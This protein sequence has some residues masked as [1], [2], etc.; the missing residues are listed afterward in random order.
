MD[1]IFK[2]IKI[3]LNISVLIILC[4]FIFIIFMP[5]HNSYSNS[6]V[7][8]SY[9]NSTNENNML[10]N[11][12]FSL[13]VKD[14]TYKT[15]SV[16]NISK[17]KGFYSAFREG[18]LNRAK[19]MTEV[20]WTPKYNLIEKEGFYVFLKGKTYTGVPYSMDP[21]QVS[22]P[23][24]FLYMINDSKI[25][26][27]NDCSGFVSA[28]WGVNRQ[29]TLTLLN[30]VKDGYKLDGKT[31]CQISWDD[32]EPG[33]ALLLDNGE[34]DGHVMLYIDSDKNNSDNLN[35]YEQNIAT[36]TPYEPIPVAREDVRSKSLLMKYGYI[37]IRII[38]N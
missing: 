20:K 34:G 21:Y 14:V 31:V 16:S 11:L 9:S 33:D 3:T 2:S 19:A 13:S 8:N 17:D 5:V 30:E 6:T 23:N 25:L 27:G 7:H 4:L 1:M 12:P 37:P 28:A 26:Y 15:K 36:V 32:L 29:T 24:N 22:S 18:I 35:V 38:D 10:I